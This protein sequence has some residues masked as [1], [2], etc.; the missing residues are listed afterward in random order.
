[1]SSWVSLFCNWHF[2]QLFSS[3]HISCP[4]QCSLLSCTR[5][6]VALIPNFSLN[7]CVLILSYTLTLHIWFLSN[8]LESF[9]CKFYST[10]QHVVLTQSSYSL[11]LSLIKMICYHQLSLN[12]FLPVL[13]L[14]TLASLQ[15]L[16]YNLL[17]LRKQAILWSC[18]Y[19]II[20]QN[21]E[22]NH[23]QMFWLN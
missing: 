10:V 1:M 3:I 8:L 5:H 19:F 21:F 7:T 16:Y 11:P 18:D 17:M 6:L 2:I 4:C 23:V 9:A 15:M 22:F 13:T 12:I 20:G 14:A